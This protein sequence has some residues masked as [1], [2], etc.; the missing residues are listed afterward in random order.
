M[1]GDYSRSY[2]VLLESF[3]HLWVLMPLWQ[4]FIWDWLLSS[5]DELEKMKCGFDVPTI[6]PAAVRQL[7]ILPKLSRFP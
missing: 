4:A 7:S 2:T 3:Y 5:S 1:M 6:L